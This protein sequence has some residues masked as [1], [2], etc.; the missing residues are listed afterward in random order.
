LST[1][2]M[3][4]LSAPRDTGALASPPT[5]KGP[6]NAGPFTSQAVDGW[7]TSSRPCRACRRRRPRLPSRAPRPR[8]PP[9]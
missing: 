3:R 1:R 5:T 7:L 8:S 6:A 9:W 4:D 2:A